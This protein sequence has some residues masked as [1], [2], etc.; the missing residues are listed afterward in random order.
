MA[1]GVRLADDYKNVIRKTQALYR[2]PR[3]TTPHR[4]NIVRFI[5]RKGAGRQRLQISNAIYGHHTPRHHRRAH[6]GVGKVVPYHSI[7]SRYE[8]IICWESCA[9][10]GVGQINL[11]RYTPELAVTVADDLVVLGY[12]DLGGVF[13]CKLISA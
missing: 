5:F 13:A 10:S 9:S 12:L 4:F 2:G 11:P 8:G 1:N 6:V 3:I 7:P